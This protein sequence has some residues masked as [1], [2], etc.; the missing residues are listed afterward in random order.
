ME[1]AELHVL[2]DVRRHASKKCF[3]VTSPFPVS[4]VVFGIENRAMTTKCFAWH[5][6]H[7]KL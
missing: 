2:V 3:L 4:E 1:E 7:Q 5:I 6:P